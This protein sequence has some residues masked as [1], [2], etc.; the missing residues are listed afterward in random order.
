MPTPKTEVGKKQ[1]NNQVLIPYKHFVSRM[2][3]YFPNRWPLSYLNLTKNMKTYIRRQQ[4]KDFKH[5]DIKKNHHHQ[6]S[7]VALQ[8]W[9]HY[10]RIKS[11]LTV[12]PQVLLLRGLFVPQDLFHSVYFEYEENC[13]HDRLLSLNYAFC[14]IKRLIKTSEPVYTD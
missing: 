13:T 2:S 3:S 9:Q 12:V 6:A 7:L 1:T 8:I 10:S 11:Q 5:Q 14:H 4:H